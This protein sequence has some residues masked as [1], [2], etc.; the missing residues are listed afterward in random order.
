[1]GC[2]FKC[3]ENQ[4]KTRHKFNKPQSFA[5]CGFRKTAM[6][7][8]GGRS[9]QIGVHPLWPETYPTLPIRAYSSRVLSGGNASGNFR[10]SGKDRR[11][12]LW[13]N[14]W[15]GEVQSN[16][17]IL[18]KTDC[19]GGWSKGSQQPQHQ[20]KTSALPMDRPSFP[21]SQ[22]PD[23]KAGVAREKSV[24]EQ[25]C[26]V[27]QAH[28]EGSGGLQGVYSATFAI[29]N[30]APTSLMVS[31]SNHAPQPRS[32]YENGNPWVAVFDQCTRML[33]NCQGS[34]VSMS[35]LKKPGRFSSGVQ[36]V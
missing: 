14:P 12:G 1:M 15:A 8:V 30:T 2:P 23:A 4:A 20:P 31:L 18:G 35:S 10:K 28:H 27:R 21:P 34:L 11:F 17:A 29:S 32:G 3:R 36:S 6:L 25:P 19:R 5:A 16:R 9:C 24:A 13:E 22:Q 7:S 26:V 33:R